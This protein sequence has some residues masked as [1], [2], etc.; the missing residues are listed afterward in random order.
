MRIADK[1]SNLQTNKMVQRYRRRNNIPSACNNSIKRSVL[2]PQRVLTRGNVKNTN[3]VKTKDKNN[4][5]MKPVSEKKY[6]NPLNDKNVR[7]KRNGDGSNISASMLGIGLEVAHYFSE[8][9]KENVL[10]VCIRN[11]Y[12]NLLIHLL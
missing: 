10:M 2:K 8:A 12:N 6:N 11:L 7:N 3:N 4:E 1:N 9:N 5:I